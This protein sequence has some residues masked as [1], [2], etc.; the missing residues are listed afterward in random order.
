MTF[1]NEQ[2]QAEFAAF[3]AYFAQASKQPFTAAR[4]SL[5]N[6]LRSIAVGQFGNA[7][8]QELVRDNRPAPEPKSEVKLGKPTGGGSSRRNQSPGQPTAPKP[9]SP[10]DLRLKERAEREGRLGVPAVVAGDKDPDV[11]FAKVI[12]QPGKIVTIEVP[13][14]RQRKADGTD[15]AE[16]SKRPANFVAEPDPLAEIELSTG[17]TFDT[18]TGRTVTDLFADA[19]NLNAKDLVE[20]YKRDLIYEYLFNAGESKDNL[21]QKTDRQLANILKKKVSEA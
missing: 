13:I 3:A 11:K 17:A 15:I 8:W 12:E 16:F 20:K 19:T 7:A 6:N 1:N 5:V 18:G 14:K 4:R 21:D 10:R 9:G 2:K